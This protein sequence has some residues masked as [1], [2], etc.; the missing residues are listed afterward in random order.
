MWGLLSVGFSGVVGGTVSSGS[1]V[2]YGFL[3]P[4]ISDTV[5]PAALINASSALSPASS[6]APTKP[7]ALALGLS[8]KTSPGTVGGTVVCGTSSAVAFLFG[9]G[10]SPGPL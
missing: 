5:D 8:D 6:D 2:A 4:V 9:A 7:S 10:C 3:L 1:S